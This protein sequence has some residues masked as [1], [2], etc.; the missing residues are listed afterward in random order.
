MEEIEMLEIN[1]SHLFTFQAHR[2][3]QSPH[4]IY[5]ITFPYVVHEHKTQIQRNG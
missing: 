3:I 2:R 4:T 1:S 5:T